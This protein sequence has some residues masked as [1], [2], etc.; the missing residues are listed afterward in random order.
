MLIDWPHRKITTSI[1]RYRWLLKRY[2]AYRKAH[3]DRK[4]VYYRGQDKWEPLPKE[5]R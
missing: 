1:R 5:F 4:P 3:H 2:K